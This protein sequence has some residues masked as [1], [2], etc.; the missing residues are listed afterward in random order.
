MYPMK[1]ITSS[2][3]QILMFPLDGKVVTIDQ[4]T[5]YENRAFEALEN[6]LPH[7]SGSTV[8][9]PCINGCPSIF[10][11]SLLLGIYEGPSPTIPLDYTHFMYTL[12]F[13]P[14][15]AIVTN[16]SSKNAPPTS[17]LSIDD[18]TLVDPIQVPFLFPLSGMST[19]PVMATLQLPDLTIG[20]PIWYLT[21]PD[22]SRIPKTHLLLQPICYH[23]GLFPVVEE[24]P[25]GN[26]F[27]PIFGLLC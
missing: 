1:A 24:N 16:A 22:M 13:K 12:S 18:H 27:K 3:F 15:F 21:P 11:D 19:T 14:E 4:L 23:S 6:V 25:R 2:V 8:S 5:F 9:T 17:S 10:K 26:H 20:L 7:I